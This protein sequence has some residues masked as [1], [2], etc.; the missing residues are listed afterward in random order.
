MSLNFHTLVLL[1]VCCNSFACRNSPSSNLNTNLGPV[2]NVEVRNRYQS[3]R[4]KLDAAHCNSSGEDVRV[5]FAG[6]SLFQSFKYNI[7]GSVVQAMA[8]SRYWPDE[9]DL[10]RFDPPYSGVYRDKVGNLSILAPEDFGGHASQRTLEIDGKKVTVCFL[11]L[12]VVWDQAASILLEEARRF[13][14]DSVIMTGGGVTT[15]PNVGQFEGGALN[16]A[17]A[18]TGY[19]IYGRPIPVNLPEIDSQSS[20]APIL[21]P[22]QPGVE[23]EISMLWNQDNLASVTHETAASIR[24]QNQNKIFEVVA[25]PAARSRNIYLCNNISYIALH[26]AKGIP[27][28]LAGGLL[29]FSKPK[30]DSL[31]FVYRSLI[32]SSRNVVQVDLDGAFDNIKMVGF[33]HIPDTRT[34]EAQTMIGWAKVF[35]KAMTN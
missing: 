28:S 22:K 14:P 1:L 8:S 12:E 31:D 30:S 25:E 3:Y 18:L 13:K 10:D 33:N 15:T 11:L 16:R 6:Y 27:I 23:E 21:D 5:I 24:R 20:Y 26:A 2:G 34:D 29:R 32:D 4:S 19:D 35:A 17:M 9:V 7:S